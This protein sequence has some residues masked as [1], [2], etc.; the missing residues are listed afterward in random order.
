MPSYCC[1][2]DAHPN[3]GINNSRM[4]AARLQQSNQGGVDQLHSPELAAAEAAAGAAGGLLLPSVPL[5]LL[6]AFACA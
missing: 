1:Q 3:A 5:L 2:A 4:K 6:L